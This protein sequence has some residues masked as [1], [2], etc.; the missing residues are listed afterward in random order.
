[1]LFPVRIFFFRRNSGQ[2]RWVVP[3]QVSGRIFLGFFWG[4]EYSGIPVFNP[5]IP[6]PQ[7]RPTVAYSTVASYA[8]YG[9][10]GVLT[11]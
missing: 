9:V 6:V 8:K 2:F 7:A 10:L 5:N 3:E 1:M 4:Y 11:L